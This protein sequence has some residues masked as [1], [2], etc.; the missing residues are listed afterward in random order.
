MSKTIMLIMVGKRRETAVEV[1]KL[2]TEYGCS[3]KTRLGIHSA[4]GDA[5]TEDGLIILELAGKEEEHKEL[6]GKLSVLKCL[7]V[8]ME[9]MTVKN[10]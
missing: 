2:L 4:A 9:K 1:Q 7:T 3:I 8:K 5:C 6:F 10:C